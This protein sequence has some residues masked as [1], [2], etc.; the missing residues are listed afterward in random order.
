MRRRLPFE[1][2]IIICDGRDLIS[3]SS[4]DPFA[5]EPSRP[6]IVRFV[7]VLSRPLRTPPS[8]PISFP[9]DGEWLLR[10]LATKGRFVFGVYKRQMRAIS[11]LGQMEKLFGVPTTTRNWNT[12]NAI[13]KILKS[14]QT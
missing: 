12:I 3:V 8:I 2:E 5:G 10:V 6:D 14:R 13:V 11:Y 1:A 4:G 9:P 7:S